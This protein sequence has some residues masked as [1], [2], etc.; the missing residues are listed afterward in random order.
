METMTSGTG[1]RLRQLMICPRAAHGDRYWKVGK[2]TSILQWQTGTPILLY[3]DFNDL[4]L[5]GEGTNA[6]NERW[7][8]KGD[9]ANLKWSAKAP[10]PFLEPLTMTRFV[11]SICSRQQHSGVAGVARNCGWLLCTE[12]H[13]AVS[14]GGRNLR[15]H[16]TKYFPRTWF[17]E[18]GCFYGKIWR[19]GE[20]FKLADARRDVQCREP[21]KLCRRLRRQR[22]HPPDSLGRASATPDTQASNPVIGSGGSRHIQLGAKIIW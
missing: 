3:D 18:L 16:G 11:D 6:S 15:Q 20:R 10:I 5:T 4:S 21:C 14:N 1:S 8:I 9:P 12:W 17:C 13:G 19:L 2:L 7:N 22:S